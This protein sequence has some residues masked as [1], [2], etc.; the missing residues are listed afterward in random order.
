M[1]RNLPNR[2]DAFI[3][4][5]LEADSAFPLASYHALPDK[6]RE[7]V[8]DYW[9]PFS[10]RSSNFLSYQN[11][12]KYKRYSYG[13]IFVEVS[14]IHGTVFLYAD[15]PAVITKFLLEIEP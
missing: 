11:I 12:L 13:V 9:T 10:F 8:R 4:K 7:F 2:L 1:R 3:E 6:L 5:H 14:A 15:E